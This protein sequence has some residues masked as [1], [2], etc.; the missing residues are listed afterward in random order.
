MKH[1]STSNRRICP[2]RFDFIETYGTCR[3]SRIRVQSFF[4]DFAHL[5]DIRDLEKG[6]VASLTV[7]LTLFLLYLGKKR[8]TLGLKKLAVR[9]VVLESDAI[10][11]HHIV[12]EKLGGRV[13]GETPTIGHTKS[14]RHFVNITSEIN[15][16]IGDRLHPR[17]KSF[18]SEFFN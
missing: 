8:G 10:L 1:M 17:L 11:L 18:L 3:H 16:S 13:Y 5:V 2:R 6:L 7:F 14:L 9:I 4:R 12:V 15:L